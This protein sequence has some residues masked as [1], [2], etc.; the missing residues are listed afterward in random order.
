MPKLQYKWRPDSTHVLRGISGMSVTPSAA[1]SMDSLWAELVLRPDITDIPDTPQSS[2]VLSWKITHSGSRLN[3][4]QTAHNP[5][6]HFAI[7]VCSLT[8]LTPSYNCLWLYRCAS[9]LTV[10]RP[11]CPTRLADDAVLPFSVARYGAYLKEA[12][13]RL[14]TQFGPRLRQNGVTLGEGMGGPTGRYLTQS[15]GL[16]TACRGRWEGW[17][18]G[19]GG[20]TEK[21]CE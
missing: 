21:R 16:Q 2:C 15:S 1:H 7:C 18:A 20:R 19:G 9:L 12:F 4:M 13:G 11:S 6:S 10:P 14:E 5:G 17:E 3:S 8:W